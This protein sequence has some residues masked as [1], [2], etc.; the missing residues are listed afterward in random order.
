MYPEL[1]EILLLRPINNADTRCIKTPIGG[2]EVS[3]IKGQKIDVMN[4]F[5][6][7]SEHLKNGWHGPIG[8]GM[9]DIRSKVYSSKE[10]LLK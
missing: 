1:P 7:Y 10:S 2:M 8:N 9:M 3:C 4:A 6:L 5:V